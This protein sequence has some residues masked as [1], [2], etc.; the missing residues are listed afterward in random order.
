MPEEVISF[1]YAIKSYHPSKSL[2]RYGFWYGRINLRELIGT[3]QQCREDYC[4]NGK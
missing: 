1:V 2:Y 3:K 4:N